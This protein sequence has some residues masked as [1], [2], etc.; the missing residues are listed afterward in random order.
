MASYATV[1][2][3]ITLSGKSYT[4]AEQTRIEALLPMVS[5]ALR[6]EGTKVGRDLDVMVAADQAYANVV[7]LVTVDIIVRIMR[8]SFDGDPMS[9][10]SQS[11]L[12]YTWSG[13]YA[14]AGGGIA[15]AIMRND[16]KR[17][18]FRQ[19]RYGALQMW[20]DKGDSPADELQD[21]EFFLI[22]G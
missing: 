4:A 9:Q 15:A 20:D 6:V 10:E 22:G 5:D 16:L 13:T 18:G 17:L 1:Q 3:V 8:Q 19:Q 21:G 7:T 14:V 11:A 2:D 12:G